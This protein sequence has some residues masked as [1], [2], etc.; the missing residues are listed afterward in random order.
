MNIA[1]LSQ[2]Q[3]YEMWDVVPKVLP[4]VNAIIPAMTCAIQPKKTA[5]PKA[6]SE[7]PTSPN[8]LK[9]GRLDRESASYRSNSII[10]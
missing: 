2:K 8:G 6:A 4:V 1:K 5:N 10:Y 9:S 3:P 7:P